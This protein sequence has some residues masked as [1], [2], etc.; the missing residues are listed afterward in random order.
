MPMADRTT[1]NATSEVGSVTIRHYCQGIGDCHLLRFPRAAGGDFFML[2]DCGVHSSV[3]GGSATI[4]A[5]VA[6]IAAVT[7]GRIDVLVVTHEHWDH[8]SG[9]LTAAQA[10]AGFT[11]GAV[12]LAWTEN[13]RDRQANELDKYKREAIAALQLAHQ[14]L[15]GFATNTQLGAIG[16]GLGQVLGFL[17]GAAGEKVRDAR[18]AAVKLAPGH[19]VYHEPGAGP[20]RLAGVDGVNVYV[21]GPPRDA[22]LLGLTER[23]SEMYGLGGGLGAPMG[24]ALMAAF[25]AAPADADGDW[26]SP[27][28]P[29]FGVKLADILPAAADP[30]TKDARPI[31]GLLRDHYVGP[32]TVPGIVPRRQKPDP[33]RTDQ[34]WRRIDSDWLSLSAD[35]ALQLDNRTNNTS[36]VLAFEFAASKRVLL[37]TADA[38]VGNWLSW[39]DLTFGA[40][41]D[42]VKG[43]DLLARTVYLKVGHHGSH[44]ATLKAKGLERMTDPDLAAFV[45]VNE[46][47]AKR[48]GWGQMPFHGILEDLRSRTA[49]RV[50]RADDVWLRAGPLPD[51]FATPSGAVKGVRYDTSGQALWVELDI[52]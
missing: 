26:D 21:L 28:D 35:L 47:D 24:R 7:G 8:V 40:G 10:F 38:Q 29:E 4:A 50:I 16:Q 12:W 33:N 3:R 31:V 23:D 27:F 25:G 14:Q 1:T 20:L 6:D 5:I 17:F 51:V 48:I 13:P 43:P 37:F 46:Q 22:R 41:P 30:G 32:A 34:S 49:G 19:V 18:D 11:I 36:L 15:Q 52:A 45:P 42:A 9:F 2:I 44:N 39:T